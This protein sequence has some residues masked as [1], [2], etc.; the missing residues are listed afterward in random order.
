MATIVIEEGKSSATPLER[1]QWQPLH[2]PGTRSFSSVG[3]G[4]S[5]I[6]G[7]S[8]LISKGGPGGFMG[9]TNNIIFFIAD[10]IIGLQSPQNRHNRTIIAG[11]PLVI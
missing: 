9:P 3:M 7:C 10:D 6:N 1:S 11:Y 2:L 5:A 4:A 8:E